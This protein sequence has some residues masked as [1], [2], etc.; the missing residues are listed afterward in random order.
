M[1]I[2]SKLSLRDKRYSETPHRCKLRDGRKIKKDAEII[3]DLR[4]QQDRKMS[5]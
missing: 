4:L 5:Y 1:I 2:T 3:Q